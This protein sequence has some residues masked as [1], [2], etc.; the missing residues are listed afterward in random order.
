MRIQISFP[1]HHMM[2]WNST[3][4]LNKLSQRIP[5]PWRLDFIMAFII[6]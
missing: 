4:S 6:N 5:I 3:I 1:T 2:G